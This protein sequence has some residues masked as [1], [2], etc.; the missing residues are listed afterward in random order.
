MEESEGDIGITKAAPELLNQ[1]EAQYE[2]LLKGGCESEGDVLA[3]IE[4]LEPFQDSP[5]L[6]DKR[7]AGWVEQLSEV[8]VKDPEAEWATR[9]LYTLCK[10]RGAKV[11]SRFFSSRVT[12][13]G[14][15][16]EMLVNS[17][18]RS[19]QTRYVLLLWLSIL[20]LAPFSL[21]KFDAGFEEK[22]YD[23]VYQYLDV[24][25]KERDGAALV[26]A[27]LITR[28]D[29]RD[30]LLKRFFEDIKNNWSLGG[31]HYRLG[32]VQT[33]AVIWRIADVSGVQQF[34]YNFYDLLQEQFNEDMSAKL[35][36]FCVKNLG[37]I[38]LAFSQFTEDGIPEQVED[39]LGTLIESLGDKDTGVR[40]TASKAVAR[41]V[42]S[43]SDEDLRNEVIG[44]LFA[45]FQEDVI[46]K[47]D[48]TESLDYV[49]NSK[50]HGTILCIAEL[51]RRRLLP[52]TY[53]EELST[54]LEKALQFE[55]RRLTF[56]LGANVR[57]ASCYV[58]WSLFRVYKEIPAKVIDRIFESLVSLC[59]FD[60]EVNIRRAASAAIQE[61]I[62]RQNGVAGQLSVE[63]G[64]QLIQIVDY[65]RIGLRS[66]SFL[67]VASDVYDLGYHG[68][69]N[70]VLH[71][72]V[73]SWDPDVR[74]LGGNSV[75]LLSH[76]SLEVRQSFID[77]LI[78][79]YD[80]H[81]FEV[82]HGVLYALGELFWGDIQPRVTDLDKVIGFLEGITDRQLKDENEL[83][84]CEAFLHVF[85]CLAKHFA[86]P[87]GSDFLLFQKRS[88]SISPASQEGR[89]GCPPEKVTKEPLPTETKARIINLV[90]KLTIAMELQKPSVVENAQMVTSVL[91]PG[92]LTPDVVS[93][94]IT[95]ASNSRGVFSACFGDLNAEY[96]ADNG[97]VDALAE[98]IDPVSKVEPAVRMQAVESLGKLFKRGVISF[99][100]K[101]SRSFIVAL[102]DYT[103][104][105]RGDV[106]S[107]VREA[108]IKICCDLYS[109]MGE[110]LQAEVDKRLLRMS[111]EVL[112]KLR[113]ASAQAI[114]RP[115]AAVDIVK[116]LPEDFD[117][118]GHIYFP[119]M[120]QLAGH[121]PAEQLR[122]F[123]RG[124]VVSAGAQAG[125]EDTLKGSMS[126]LINYLK[127]G[128]STSVLRELVLL[129]DL[130]QYG[131]KVAICTL[132]VLHQLLE[133]GVP[134]PDKLLWS[135]Y[136]KAYN[137][138]IN[139]KSLARI[140]PS[141]DIITTLASIGCP[142]AIKRLPVLC[143]HF[144]PEVRT[145]AAET[146][147]EISINERNTDQ[148]PLNTIGDSDFS[149]PINQL[150]PQLSSIEKLA[151]SLA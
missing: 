56:A 112:N 28:A 63:E 49:S 137:M 147:Y 42:H 17:G 23:T 148:T 76:K 144:S 58:C 109:D 33:T 64:L 27:R 66:R 107:W 150:K 48:G 81:D 86:A 138:H 44:A 129:C 71:K 94:W 100:N 21:D 106:G 20:V 5:Q 108:A 15:V 111:V 119:H 2:K 113:L 54:V 45:I 123:L 47:K 149:L 128:Q 26:M 121:L 104:D 135:I 84:N 98:I 1:I 122:E 101:S 133:S 78:S 141:V 89:E 117:R 14:E 103:V 114:Q 74:R 59:S 68:V 127:D 73:C 130:K 6:L 34:L 92:I 131:P 16:V 52:P 18:G 88:K 40:Y 29:V 38:S 139:T 72:G 65:L 37:R 145:K 105:S 87:T 50:W 46:V 102:D 110:D 151:T 32:I 95:R 55:Q 69:V 96:V 8:Y 91:P 60:R 77:S 61:G 126:A 19:W 39:I 43:L 4:V 30:T 99:D 24:S 41:I 53:F 116:S 25:G 57:D 9:V 75:Q 143:R 136:V 7:L 10:I 3:L 12:L 51:L 134:V 70:S 31:L 35:R 125:S 62:G 142:F 82:Q 124:Y 146:L 22:L 11:V 118:S 36:K 80:P 85:R 83:L 93:H 13:L 120:V 79:M 132:R 97:V 67:E 140:K 115:K 90:D